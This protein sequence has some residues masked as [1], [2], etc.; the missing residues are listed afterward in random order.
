[1]MIN[2]PIKKQII[3]IWDN[4]VKTNTPDVNLKG[5]ILDDIDKRRLVAIE[6]IKVMISDFFSGVINIHE[7]KTDLDSYNK[8]NNLWGFTAAKGQMFFNQLVRTSDQQIE[9]LTT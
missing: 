7:F 6:E 3:E 5:E 8:Q 1:M 9:K 4:Y 2:E